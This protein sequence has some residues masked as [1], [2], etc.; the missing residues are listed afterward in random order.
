MSFHDPED[1]Y[2]D[3]SDEELLELEM[4]YEYERDCDYERHKEENN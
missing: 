1:P 2:A 3:L 4:R